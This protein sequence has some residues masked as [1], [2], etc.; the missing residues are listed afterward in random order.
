MT[1][2]HEA[3]ITKKGSTKEAQP[4]NGP[5]VASEAVR[6][7]VGILLPLV[8]CSMFLPLFMGVLCLVFVLLCS[9]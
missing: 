5:P 6:Y 9:T 3:Q 1:D 2:K 7:K 8:Y 4:L